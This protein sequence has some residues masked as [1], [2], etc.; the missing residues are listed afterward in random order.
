MAKEYTV[1]CKAD[2]HSKEERQSFKE[3]LIKECSEV[4]HFQEYYLTKPA[5]KFFLTWDTKVTI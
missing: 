2:F 4:F 3:W 1:E 5:P